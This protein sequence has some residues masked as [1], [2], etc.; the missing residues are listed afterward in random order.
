MSILTYLKATGKTFLHSFKF[1]L[2]FVFVLVYEL[3][4]VLGLALLSWVLAQVLGSIATNIGDVNPYQFGAETMT[5]MQTFLTNSVLA[6]VLFLFAVFI[7]YAIVQALCWGHILNKTFSAKAIARF[8]LMNIVWLI[9]WTL[10]SWF[11]IAG[12]KGNFAVTAVVVVSVLFVHLSWLYQRA[13]LSNGIKKSVSIAFNTGF[14]DVLTFI[15]PYLL[16]LIVLWVWAQLW[17]V[18]VVLLQSRGILL[19][20]GSAFTAVFLACVILAAFFAWL[21]FYF[22]FYS[23]IE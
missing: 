15:I 10:V 21:K 17:F 9:P 16:A 3:L 14:G 1:K 11:V 8:V 12:V 19:E 7:W 13:V 6:A 23:K 4:F 2:P 22:N 5:Q 20:A 18:I